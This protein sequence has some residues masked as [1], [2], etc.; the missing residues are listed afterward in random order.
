MVV[1]LHTRYDIFLL[2]GDAVNTEP[3][4][5]IDI[6][7]AIRLTGKSKRTLMRWKLTKKVQARTIDQEFVQR[8]R[9]TVFN[10]SDVLNAVSSEEAIGGAAH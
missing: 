5:W 3:E 7:E 9:R 6:D 2:G 8:Q 4:E 1:F 10:K